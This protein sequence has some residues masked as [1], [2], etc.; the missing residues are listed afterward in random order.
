MSRIRVALGDV[1]AA[2]LRDILAQITGLQPDMELV[3]EIP[4]IDLK[5][6]VADQKPDV[7]ICDVR[8]QDLPDICRDLFAEP[9][10]PVVVGLAR[11]GREAA[12]YIPNAGAAQLMS[13]VRSAIGHLVESPRVI[14][15]GRPSDGERD[16]AATDPYT[17]NADCL[18]D[19]LRALDLALLAEVDAFESTTWDEGPQRL[20]GLAVSPEE[21]R[22]LLQ[23]S[24]PPTGPRQG[25]ELKR[26]RQRMS[27]WISKRVGATSGRPDAPP[28]VRLIDRFHLDPFEQFCLTAGLATEIDRNKYGK[29]FALLQDDVHRKQPSWELLL[30]LY[31]GSTEGTR[32]D[33]ARAFDASRPLRRWNLLRLGPREAGEPAAPFGRRVELD[34]RMSRFLLGLSE[35]GPQMEEFA[36]VGAWE[37]EPWHIASAGT[38][39]DRL[40][41]LVA[42]VISGQR[43]A[44]SRLV[45]H[46]YGRRGSGRRALIAAI[47]RRHNLRVL[48]IDTARLATLPHPNLE[49]AL[50]LLA[51]EAVL[52]PTALVLENIDPLIDDESPTPSPAQALGPLARAL[53]T[54]SP[55]AFVV[56][57][58]KW[59]PEGLFNEGTFQSVFLDLP[60][61]EETKNIWTAALRNVQLAPETGGAEAAGT[62]LAS[63][64][65]LSAGQMHDALASAQTRA[66]WDKPG[67]GGWLTLA[68]L[69]QGC[70]EQCSHRLGTLARQV[71][72]GFGWKDLVLPDKPHEQLRELETAIRNASGVLQDWD[73]QSRLPYGRGITA[74]FAGPSGTGKTMAAGI[75]ARELGLD[76]YKIDLSR[77]VSKYIGE[78]EKNLDRIFQQAEDAN[79][80]LFFDEADALFGKRSAIKDAHD[81]YANIEIAYLLQKMEERLGVTILATNLQANMDEAF[82]RRIRF[83]IEFPMPEFAQRLEIWRSSLP[84]QLQL[85]DD[86]DLT[87]LARRLRVSGGAIM[88]VCVGAASLAYTPGGVIRMEHFA[89]AAKR[90]LEKLGHQYNESDF[91]P[92]ELAG[93]GGREPRA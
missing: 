89:R 4:Q 42:D 12:V 2:M 93:A 41:R 10:P 92:G 51:R 24:G 40:V 11:E 18:N 87:V 26:R 53:Q 86:V 6:A 85:A 70:R 7:L 52:E 33:A 62:E 61:F 78:T 45:V 65:R 23:A 21:V 54:F 8:P 47:C 44:P 37:P 46:L 9:N 16:G 58:R 34:D 75:L 71:T 76:L 72:T 59:T 15:L 67:G 28:F 25:G 22:A 57:Q 32:W 64:F 90:E 38:L 1:Q 43:G 84:K 80:M 3:G 29:A 63:R 39:E 66:L 49:E 69:Y 48:R 36:T 60:D 19:Q 91:V 31:E 81:R 56:G 73:F 14:E 5:A 13:V 35:L 82:M 50:V 17:S 83:G 20:Q 77:V 30:R 74:L 88:N 27:E 68:D 55:I 79:A